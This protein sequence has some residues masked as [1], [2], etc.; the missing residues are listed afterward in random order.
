M[1]TFNNSEVKMAGIYYKFQK[2]AKLYKQKKAI[3]TEENYI[4]Y[5]SL[6]DKADLFEKYF[7]EI[8]FDEETV[9]CLICDN[10]IEFLTCYLTAAK[11]NIVFIPIDTRLSYEDMKRI[12][13]CINPN[14]F[15][16]GKKYSDTG[17]RL[18]CEINTD[19]AIFIN[20]VSNTVDFIFHKM[21]HAKNVNFLKDDFTILFSSGSTGNPK[22]VVFSQDVIIRQINISSRHFEITDS[23]R[24][25]CPV[26]LAHSY[27][28]FDHAL[29]SLFAGSTLYLPN[30]NSISPRLILEMV[31]NEKITFFG[32]LP[33]MYEMM[34]SMH[35][36]KNY[37]LSSIRY[38]ICG[39]APLLK[40]TMDKFEKKYGKRINQVYGLTETGYISFNKA[41]T[42]T[43][44]IGKALEELTVRIVDGEGN[45]C[46]ADNEGELTIKLDSMVARGYFN[47][48]VEYEAMYKNG[49]FYTKDIVK[50]DKEGYLYY[51]SRISDFI[52]VGANKVS[53]FEIEKVINS[54]KGVSESAVIG[55]TNEFGHQDICAVVVPEE[56]A[57]KNYLKNEILTHCIKNLAPFK[58]PAEIKFIDKLPKTLLGKVKKTDLV[59]LFKRR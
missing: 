54:V 32:T 8:G 30:I 17:Y 46:E 15:I 58:R 47:N 25:L 19:R 24:I 6:K 7:D 50:K 3:V 45:E 11:K 36:N 35:V 51:C 34:A 27:G 28:I 12:V 55:V 14:A 9:I 39:G 23:D 2:I 52:N 31:Q 4:T 16:C 13:T 22:G 29:T 21:K 49:W 10:S 48:P 38:M 33:F 37:D 57:D 1:V 59:E 26:T 5:E 42:N 40:E 56:S 43:G 53:P 20:S 41:G 18:L 44:S